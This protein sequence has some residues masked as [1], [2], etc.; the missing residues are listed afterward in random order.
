MAIAKVFSYLCLG[1][2]NV[3]LDFHE[4]SYTR[5]DT[6]SSYNI[7]WTYFSYIHSTEFA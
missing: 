4:V 6:V 2:A 7:M 5:I 3:N 1:N